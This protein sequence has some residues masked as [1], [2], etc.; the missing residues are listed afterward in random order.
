MVYTA[1]KKLLMVWAE[2]QSDWFWAAWDRVESLYDNINGLEVA[3]MA[4]PFW[5]TEFAQHAIR[6]FFGGVLPF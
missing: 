6:V 4:A 5:D 3:G 2:R 1:G